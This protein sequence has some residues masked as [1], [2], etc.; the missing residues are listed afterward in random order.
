MRLL[1]NKRKKL[2]QL[3]AEY[4]K[5]TAQRADQALAGQPAA[6]VGRGRGPETV[7]TPEAVLAQIQ[8]V[9]TEPDT[10]PCDFCARVLDFA[11]DTVE[12]VVLGIRG[13]AYGRGAVSA[14]GVLPKGAP[15]ALLACGTCA[16]NLFLR[17]DEAPQLPPVDGTG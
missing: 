6:A 11:D 15:E 5:L 13:W 17:W 3:T 9:A 14:D 4:R 12:K 8:H 1:T 2:D 10:A 7:R 16:R